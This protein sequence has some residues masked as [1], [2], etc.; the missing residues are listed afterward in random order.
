MSELP[1]S[2]L[3]PYAP[4]QAEVLGAEGLPPQPMLRPRSTK[5]AIT[6]LL[7]KVGMVSW[8]LW[9]MVQDGRFTEFWNSYLD[10]PIG[11]L[12]LLLSG[13]GLFLLIATH[14]A[15]AA[16]VLTSLALLLLCS[17][18]V[19]NGYHEW[20]DRGRFLPLPQASFEVAMYLAV[21]S[22]VL[23]LSYRFIIGLP[24]RRYY[25]IGK[26]WDEDEEA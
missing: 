1:G 22:A 5:W 7:L 16:Y 19:W 9:T 2:P 26:A 25:R 8:I 17:D 12:S 15:R 20:M 23:Y 21:M 3:N 6:M 10:A 13:L 14:R 4:P 24:S 11:L 18:G